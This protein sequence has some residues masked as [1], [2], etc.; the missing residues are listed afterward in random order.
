MAPSSSCEATS[1]GDPPGADAASIF[2]MP[3]RMPFAAGS[4]GSLAFA[5]SA[6][7]LPMPPSR[8]PV[9]GGGAG[10]GGAGAVN[11][12]APDESGKIGGCQASAPTRLA[13]MSDQ[14]AARGSGGGAGRL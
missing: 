6:N 8:P 4:H 2:A 7:I 3:P 9:G 12:N 13:G 11:G 14:Y 10:G 5:R 1:D